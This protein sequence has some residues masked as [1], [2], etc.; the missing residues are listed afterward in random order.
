MRAREPETIV[1]RTNR[2]FKSGSTETVRVFP[3][4]FDQTARYI[5]PILG[6]TPATSRVEVTGGRVLIRYGPWRV[7]VDRR[8]I[9]AVTASGPFKAW[10][11]IGP[12]LSIADRGLT[13]GTSIRGGVCLQ[14][15]HPVGVLAPRQLLAHPALTVTVDDPGALIRL[16]R[17]GLLRRL[18][19]RELLS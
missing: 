15:R 1:V 2:L 3:F 18:S 8:N 12:R 13:F 10:K 6:V 11:A 19:L 7:T 14:M 4:R 9:R 5:L 16:L 17:P